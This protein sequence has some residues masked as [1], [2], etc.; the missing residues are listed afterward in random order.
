MMTAWLK[1]LFVAFCNAQFQFVQLFDT[2][3][4]TSIESVDVLLRSGSSA[5]ATDFTESAGRRGHSAQLLASEILTFTSVVYRIDAKALAADAMR[6]HGWRLSASLTVEHVGSLTTVG[7]GFSVTYGDIPPAGQYFDVQSRT[8]DYVDCGLARNSSRANVAICHMVY[9]MGIRPLGI[10]VLLNRSQPLVS[11]SPGAIIASPDRRAVTVLF[12]QRPNSTNVASRGLMLDLLGSFSNPPS[13]PLAGWMFGA[14]TGSST[15]LV[16][17]DHV[18][19]S[20]IADSCAPAQIGC[21]ANSIVLPF[22]DGSVVCAT[23]NGSLPSAGE[24]HTTSIAYEGHESWAPYNGNSIVRYVSMDAQRRIYAL[25]VENVANGFRW[26][27]NRTGLCTFDVVQF[28]AVAAIMQMSTD[29]LA[30]GSIPTFVTVDGRTTVKL[31]LP[32]VIGPVTSGSVGGMSTALASS[33][34]SQTSASAVTTVASLA[35]PSSDAAVIGGVVGGV[36]GLLV[37]GGLLFY[38][39]SRKRAREPSMSPSSSAVEAPVAATNPNKN[40][41][42]YTTLSSAPIVYDQGVDMPRTSDRIYDSGNVSIH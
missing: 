3:L 26:L 32:S 9:D 40:N 19:L 38:C 8:D 13:V 12:E 17:V 7:D 37:V 10:H 14:R 18:V 2:S 11:A 31:T 5:T 23:L 34:V 4:N 28:K 22:A 39:L 6:T 36:I 15:L 41:A 20:V 42:I 30:S 25:E 1:L 33:I 24:N 16:R 27:L 21:A 35:S 29:G